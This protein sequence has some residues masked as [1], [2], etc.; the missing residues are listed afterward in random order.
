VDWFLAGDEGLRHASQAAG[1][2]VTLA[3]VPGGS[4]SLGREDGDRTVLIELGEA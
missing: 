1:E 2:A 4:W 3:R